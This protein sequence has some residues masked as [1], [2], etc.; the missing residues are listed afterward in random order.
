M[1]TQHQSLSSFVESRSKGYRLH[2]VELWN[3]GTFDEHI[4][5]VAPKGQST[6]LIGQNGSGKSTLV[7]A[8]LTLLVRPGVRNFNV[9]AGAKKRERDE[10]SYLLGAYDRGSDDDGGVRVKYLRPKGEKYSVILACF[11]NQGIDKV[12]TIAQVL[13]LAGDQSVEKVY[14]FAEGERSIREDFGHLESTEN[15]VKV[16]KGRGIRATR[17]FQEFEAWFSKATHVKP[18]AMEVFNQ[19]VAVKD[20]QRL[21]DFIRDHM[22]EPHNWEEKF[23]RLLG[24]FTQLSEA[25]DSLVRAR[26]QRDLLEPVARIGEEYRQAKTRL[27]RAERLVHASAAYF[28]QRTVD[29]FVPAIAEKE[30]QRR[31]IAEQRE[32]VKE[33]IRVLQERT[34]LL[35]NEIEN[36]GGD[37]L[38]LIPGLIAFEGAHAGQKRKAH[39]RFQ[40]A[41]DRLSL[42]VEVHDEASLV[43]V[44][45]RVAELQA[46]L[47]AEAAR[48]TSERDA[49]LLVRG[50]ARRDLV[51]CRE[52]LDGLNRRKENIP[53]WSVQ[54]RDALCRELGL[55][56]REF[57]FAAELM[58]VSATARDWESS[59]EKVLRGLALSLL[60][61]DRYYRTV[62]QYIDR[63]RLTAQGRGQR[64]VYL[65]VAARP[66]G[67]GTKPD[68]NSLVGKLDFR[69]GHSLLP[70][71]KGELLDRFDY[72]CCET[73]EE[74]H[75]QRGMA[76]TRNRHVKAG[77]QRHE[78]DDREQAVDPRN[79][80]LGWDNRGKKQRIAAEIKRLEAIDAVESSKIQTVDDATAQLQV[81]NGAILEIQ[82]VTTFAELDFATNDRE[83]RRLE[84][85]RDA[86][87]TGSSTLRSLRTRLSDT[88]AE[89][90]DLRQRDEGLVGDEREHKLR[91][92]QANTL[93]VNARSE[94][95]RREA[96]GRLEA[97]REVF[98][99]LD[100]ELVSPPLTTDN[101]FD[102]RER[103]RREQDRR[104][105][106]L[107]EEVAPKQNHLTE[108]MSRFLRSAPEESADL[109]ASVDYLGS[110]LGL[111]QRILEDD[112][113]RHEKRFKERLNRNVIEDIGFFR[114]ALEQERRKIED[115]IELLNAS[116]QKLEYR[117]GTHIQLEPRPIRDVDVT[118]FQ[119]R[120][121]ECVEGSF[122]DTAEAN[123]ARFHSDQG[124]DSAVAG[125]GESHLAEQGHRCPSLVRFSRG[126][127]RPR[128]GQVG[129]GVP[130]QQWAVWRGEG[131][132]GIHDPGGCDRVP[133]RPQSGELHQRPLSLCGCRR[134]VLQGRRPTRR[135]RLGPVQ[136]V[137]TPSA[138]CGPLGCQG[139]SH[140][141][142]RRF[143]SPRG[144]EEQSVSD[145]R[146][147]SGSV[148]GVR[149]TS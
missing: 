62:S 19:T 39:G 59:I 66:A 63:T 110:F 8:I 108:A 56:L 91:I 88:E 79:F 119:T 133:I 58:Q 85:E 36:V 11:R 49:S 43:S 141:T 144:K 22:L 127:H 25:H 143:V 77:R 10:R 98:S 122:E 125:R 96:G 146:D 86:I 130:R 83:V 89:E 28:A 82:R 107:K 54:L 138:D 13:Y 73:I 87:E 75:E 42:S 105:A 74:F 32:T 102:R 131:Q 101:F 147:D 139:A 35:R 72:R 136:A 51:T 114:S 9:A 93:V 5:T 137:R 112:L 23:D 90:A 81:L 65:H 18:K 99:E 45:T 3:W 149:R 31:E 41:L 126:R 115:K 94:L 61:P 128:D 60:V 111:R 57:P 78:K 95:S 123:E 124:A 106:D 103:F 109:S 97:D 34:R 70:W 12:F 116:L 71:L 55:P 64:L 100:S 4:F 6:L 140:S 16:L 80:V 29:L 38:K 7:D 69:E 37:R 50:E 27:D 117:L 121:R 67:P 26:Q 24:H 15:I 148:R 132:A 76:I 118:D 142:V 33:Q 129:L 135:V 17:T 92:E 46:E 113:P 104:I 84:E 120:L 53:E 2:K 1:I 40:E 30:R 134:D 48:L 44:W 14:C 52:E 20:I 47:T 68:R 145:L 21:N